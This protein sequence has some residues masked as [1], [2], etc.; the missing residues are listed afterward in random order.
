MATFETDGFQVRP[1]R[2]P[3]GPMGLEI[4]TPP[5]SMALLKQLLSKHFFLSVK[6]KRP[7][8]SLLPV[9][10]W[11]VLVAILYNTFESIG[12]DDPS[13]IRL[14][15]LLEVIILPLYLTM[16]VAQSMAVAVADIVSEKEDKMKVIQ[17]V[18]GLPASVYW[19]SWYIYYTLVAVGCIAIVF[20]VLFG[21]QPI[22]SGLNVVILIIVWYLAFMQQFVVVCVLSAL[23]D[24][25]KIA[26][27]ASSFLNLLLMGLAS[28]MQGFLTGK[29]Q[30]AWYLASLLP[31]TNTFNLW[32]SVFYHKSDYYCT[33]TDE[34]TQ[35]CVRPGLTFSNLFADHVCVG[36]YYQDAA[37]TDCAYPL[38]YDI[39][40]VGSSLLMMLFNIVLYAVV[41]WWI[42]NVRQGKY[43]SARPFCF[44]LDPRWW[45]T[46]SAREARLLDAD[47]GGHGTQVAM[48]IR[49]LTK[50]FNNQVAVD[51]LSL[52]ILGSEIFALLGHNGA[53]KTTAINCIVGL[54]PPS[55]GGAVVNGFDIATN[56]ESAR[57]QLSICPQDD[58]LYKEFT[59]RRHLIFFASLR[60]V[61]PETV[62]ERVMGVLTALGMPEK[63]DAACHTL[64]GGQ[65]RRL[66]VATALL[67]NSPISFLDEPTSGM[68]PSSRRE[69]WGILLDMKAQGRCVIFTT[70][71]LEEADVL[72]DRKAVLARGKVMAVGTSREL[73]MQFGLGY[74]L[75]LE[76]T[77]G[78][79][80][81]SKLTNIRNLVGTHISG[82]ME[83]EVAVEEHAQASDA[84]VVAKF[85]LP[86]AEVK[87]FGPLLTAL[88]EGKA[89]LGVDDYNIEMTSLEEVF[90]ALGQQAENAPG[91][92]RNTDF[93]E[94][95]AESASQQHREESNF[96]RTVGALTRIRLQ[97][98]FR[99]RRSF[100]VT[101]ILPV[102]FV[103]LAIGLSSVKA[104]GA[105]NAGDDW[106]IAFYPPMAFGLATL[107]FTLTIVAERDEKTKIKHVVMAQGASPLAYWTGTAIAH[108]VST[109]P[110]LVVFVVMLLVRGG[111]F[112]TGGPLLMVLVMC[113]VYPA[114]LLLYAYCLALVFQSIETAAKY[115]ALFSLFAG[116]IPIGAEFIC[117]TIGNEFW[118]SA[119]HIA[120]SAL[121]PVY[122]L[123]GMIVNLVFKGGIMSASEVWTS[124]AAIPLYLCPVC[125]VIWGTM[126]FFQEV[127]SYHS[128]PGEFVHFDGERKDA[129]VVQ[130]ENRIQTTALDPTWEVARYE[131][132]SHTYRS[133]NGPVTAVRGISLGVRQGECFGLLGPNGAGKTTTLAVLTGEVRPPTA[134][135]VHICGHNV[136]D[137]Q[138]L[139]EAY[140]VLGVCPQVNPLWETITGEDHLHFYGRVKGVPEQRLETTVKTLLQRLGL[141]ADAKKKAGL[142]SGGMKRKLSVAIALIGYSPLL[143]LDEPSAA[144]D[145]GAKRHLWKVIKRRRADQTVVLTTHSM[146]EAEA[147]CDRLAIQVQ[148]Q[149]RCL[150]TSSH[151]KRKYG[152]GCQLELFCNEV[153][154]STSQ[155][156]LSMAAPT[157]SPVVLDFVLEFISP[158]AELIEYHSGRY[159]FQLP[160][161]NSEDGAATKLGTVFTKLQEKKEQVGIVDY[162]V[163]QPSLEQVFLRFARE[164]VSSEPA[165]HDGE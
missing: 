60:G 81:N 129:D 43:G 108:Y 52:D 59:V 104:Q 38:R 58:P 102:L 139:W 87:N 136:A 115:G 50:V 17:D 157:A 127:R 113:V 147:L 112:L 152:S 29:T 159:L 88:D 73:K 66:W 84:P 101:V 19:F 117:L 44:C 155:A 11:S 21:V 22:F 144:V 65:K 9:L 36:P 5:N 67:A 6:R 51:H 146:E 122:S 12:G 163:T 47:G 135:T 76:L 132:L 15:M 97:A 133:R 140:Q 49:E 10:L 105:G 93:A 161:R 71:Y 7:F 54:I 30:G 106:S 68:D 20:V 107:T 160:P 98:I 23:F 142:Y 46:R 137:A 100:Y 62:E 123:P 77:P 86:Y 109:F 96:Q 14:R 70:H 121:D 103:I 1:E 151:I 45:F 138:G 53:G 150:G 124:S 72:A 42:E 114:Q 83:E 131:G 18:Y 79:A 148:G 40:P 25:V 141:L 165:G 145:A 92:T 156:R 95:E 26:T 78:G 116:T 120:F 80:S 149:L 13:T 33:G 154:T 27:M 69:L 64:S 34:A 164:Q 35:H 56:L 118:S 134:G 125:C 162:S 61:S 63:L 39:F 94:V 85:M 74:H 41:A 119:L 82:A 110:L 158:R 8:S 24:T 75:T 31:Q 126:L 28:A 130:E 143:F 4:A 3:L 32:A 48:S 153:S 16:L 55:S 91:I 99:D 128:N 90:M 111:D 57:L 2:S 37:N 89:N